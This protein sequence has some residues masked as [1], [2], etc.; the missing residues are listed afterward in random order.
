YF[1]H[2]MAMYRNFINT[3]DIFSG[4]FY[5]YDTLLPIGNKTGGDD[6]PDDLPSPEFLIYAFLRIAYPITGACALIAYLRVNQITRPCDRIPPICLFLII[7][8]LVQIVI[9][10]AI[11]LWIANVICGSAISIYAFLIWF[12][13]PFSVDENPRPFFSRITAHPF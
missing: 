13:C 5:D 3:T 4:D 7:P 11:D 2:F 8:S 12:C 9:S 1:I 6:Y 10:N